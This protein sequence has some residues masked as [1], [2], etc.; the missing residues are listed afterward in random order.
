VRRA[1]AE[2]Q[3]FWWVTMAYFITDFAWIALDPICVKSPSVLLIHHVVAALY[4]LLPFHYPSTAPKMSYVMIV[5][6]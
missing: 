6:V 5:E 2:F 4:M 3:T 1:F